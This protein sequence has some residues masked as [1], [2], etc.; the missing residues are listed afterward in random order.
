MNIQQMLYDNYLKAESEIFFNQ[1]LNTMIHSQ[2][3]TAKELSALSG[4][5]ILKDEGNFQIKDYLIVTVRNDE[6]ATEDKAADN[7][8]TRQQIFFTITDVQT[9]ETTR[10][11][12][13]GYALVKIKRTKNPIPKIDDSAEDVA[14]SE[15]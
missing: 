14:E 10:G 12:R 9:S 5:L 15:E 11:V 3:F 13:R 6:P 7:R 2:T 1:L 8:L 4:F